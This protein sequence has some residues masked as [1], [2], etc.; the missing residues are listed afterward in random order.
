[1]TA[2]KPRDDLTILKPLPPYCYT[3]LAP[4]RNHGTIS[5]N[6]K[7]L[8]NICTM[9]DQRRR[10]WADVV[11]MLY[12]CF[13]F[14]EFMVVLKLLQDQHDCTIISCPIAICINTGFHWL[15]FPLSIRLSCVIFFLV[16][17][18]CTWYM[19]LT[20]FCQVAWLHGCLA[21]WL[22]GRMAVWLYGCMAA[23][24]HGCMVASLH[25]PHNMLGLILHTLSY[26]CRSVSLIK[27]VDFAGLPVW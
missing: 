7:H 24:P 22:L 13:V 19:S 20:G 6:T 16:P 8:Y 11:Q 18:T 23:W 14:S 17:V 9:L 1:M 15:I 27:V 26:Y 25:L 5:V 3:P 21:A 10:R 2:E 12:K 4:N